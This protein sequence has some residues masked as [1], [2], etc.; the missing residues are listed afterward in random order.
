MS[1]VICRTVVVA[2]AVLA[3][4]ANVPVFAQDYPGK[5][6]RIIVQ[7]TPGTSTDILAR[8]VAQ[9]MSEDW[10]QQFESHSQNSM[11]NCAQRQSLS[12]ELTPGSTR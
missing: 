4:V 10:H 5:P 1:N 7:F 6:I 9:K 8:L 3:G 12:V 2:L 11:L